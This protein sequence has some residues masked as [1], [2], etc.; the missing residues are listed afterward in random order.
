MLY[1]GGFFPISTTL[2]MGALPGSGSYVGLKFAGSIL[3]GKDRYSGDYKTA[4][5]SRKKM[6]ALIQSL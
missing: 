5:K 2:E 1:V 3:A 6:R 4:F